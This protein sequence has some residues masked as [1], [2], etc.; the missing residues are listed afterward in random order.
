[1]DICKL[2]PK[3]QESTRWQSL[4]SWQEPKEIIEC[5]NE[6]SLFSKLLMYRI[7]EDCVMN[8]KDWMCQI[9]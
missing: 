7:K 8:I 9:F 3:Q 2:R 6:R 4:V 5:T 1:M